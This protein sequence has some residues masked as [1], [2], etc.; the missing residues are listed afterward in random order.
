MAHFTMLKRVGYKKT[1]PID[2]LKGSLMERDVNSILSE[3]R[4][5]LIKEK[6]VLDNHIVP[7][8]QTSFDRRYYEDPEGIRITMDENIKFYTPLPFKRLNSSLPTP[9]PLQ[10][11]EIKFDLNLK[12]RVN[13]LIKSLHLRPKRHSKYLVGLAKLG[14]AVYI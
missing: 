11:M 6:V 2:S 1:Y 4:S 3:C 8:L 7:S 9:Y 5:L 14:F 10:V 12:E 13:K